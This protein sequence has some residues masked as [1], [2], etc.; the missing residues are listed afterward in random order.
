MNIRGIFPVLL[1]LTLWGE[2][3][4]KEVTNKPTASECETCYKVSKEA[5]GTDREELCL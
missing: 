2:I 1:V 3:Y 5:R 4:S